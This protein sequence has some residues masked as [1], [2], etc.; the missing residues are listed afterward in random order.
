MGFFNLGVKFWSRD[1]F[2]FCLKSNGF[3]FLVLIFFPHSII[4]VTL[5]P[6][7][8][9]WELD[10]KPQS[11]VNSSPCRNANVLFF[12]FTVTQ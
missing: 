6:D 5:N 12:V 8:P 7:Y 2:E 3:F 4:P 9:L 1:F 11:A 10:P